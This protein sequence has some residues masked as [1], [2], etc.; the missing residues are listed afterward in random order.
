MIKDF[1]SKFKKFLN[2]ISASSIP[3]VDVKIEWYISSRPSNIEIF[4]VRANKVTLIENMKEAVSTERRI[5]A[6]EKRPQIEERKSK[7]VTFK[8]DSK[9]KAPKDPFDLEGL[10]NVL[11]TM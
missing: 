10:Q 1:N 8:E 3:A 9:K 11:K 2:E 7:K 4:V 6:L 5:I